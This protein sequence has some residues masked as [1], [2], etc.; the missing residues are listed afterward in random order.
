M[1]NHTNN[2]LYRL[3]VGVKHRARVAKRAKSSIAHT[4]SL[5]SILSATSGAMNPIEVEILP[6][7]AYRVKN[8]PGGPRVVAKWSATFI[9]TLILAIRDQDEVWGHVESKKNLLLCK[10]PGTWFIRIYPT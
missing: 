4:Q 6:H 8:L 10:T 5:S 9:P 2:K 3:N 7:S 1:F